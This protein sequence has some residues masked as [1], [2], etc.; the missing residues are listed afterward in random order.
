MTHFERLEYDRRHKVSIPKLGYKKTV[1]VT[2]GALCISLFALLALGEAS[3]PVGR[4]PRGGAHRSEPGGES[5]EA[6]QQ[7]PVMSSPRTTDFW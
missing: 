5:S 4:Q 6:C 1:V 2:W 7:P 3:C